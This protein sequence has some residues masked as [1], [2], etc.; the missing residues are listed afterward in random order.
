MNLGPLQR[1]WLTFSAHQQQDAIV[2]VRRML[3]RRES[4]RT[5]ITLKVIRVKARRRSRAHDAW[6]RA[7]SRRKRNNKSMGRMDS[8]GHTRTDRTCHTPFSR[9][10]LP[11]HPAIFFASFQPTPSRLRTLVQK[12][13]IMGRPTVQQQL[14]NIPIPADLTNSWIFF[15]CSSCLSYAFFI[16]LVWNYSVSQKIPEDLWQFFQNGW[17]FF[18]QILCAYYAFLSTLDYKFLFNHL[19]L[20]RSYA[21]LSVTTQFTPCAQDVHHRHKRTLAFSDIFP[22]QLGIFSPNLHTCQT[23]ICTLKCKFLFNY[24]QLWRNNAIL[25]ATTQR[26]F[27]SM[28]N[29]L[30]IHYG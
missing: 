3:R 10:P 24:L 27:R 11:S 18:N 12:L 20:W 22:K 13:F 1:N 9:A 28:V 15:N 25:S 5:Y 6:K 23:F 30:S 2:S 14:R 26:T 17:E 16:V 7:C 4:I 29:I 19:Q 21:I 8:D